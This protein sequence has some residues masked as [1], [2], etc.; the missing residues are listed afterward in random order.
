[1]NRCIILIIKGNPCL[2]S[3][4]QARRNYKKWEKG[5]LDEVEVIA[6]GY[7]DRVIWKYEFRDEVEKVRQKLPGYPERGRPIEAK[8]RFQRRVNI[9]P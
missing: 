3:L 1:M 7:F 6:E 2:V 5:T 4:G 9:E 8:G